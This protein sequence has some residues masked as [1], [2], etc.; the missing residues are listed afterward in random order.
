M[1]KIIA[2]IFLF[3]ILLFIISTV[4]I[5]FKVSIL[6]GFTVLSVEMIFFSIL[7]MKIMVVGKKNG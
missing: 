5:A 2:L 3:G 1:E 4:V 6:L 7:V